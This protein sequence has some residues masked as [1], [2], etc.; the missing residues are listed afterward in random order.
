MIKQYIKKD[1]YIEYAISYK[2]GDIK[3][4]TIKYFKYDYQLRTLERQ[5]IK[6]GY[7]IELFI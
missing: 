3:E 2:N 6:K 1:K 4:K 7:K 5:L